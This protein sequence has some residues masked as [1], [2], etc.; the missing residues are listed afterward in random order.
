MVE[1]GTGT[2]QYFVK[3]VPTVYMPLAGA[4]VQTYQFSVTEHLRPIEAASAGAEAAQG[5][6][7]GVFFNYEL[8]PLRAHIE[9]KRRSAVHFL[10][11]LFGV[12]GGVFVVAG[13][14]DAFVYALLEDL[15]KGRGRGLGGGA[16]GLAKD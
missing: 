13:V 8:S 5:V 14:A 4:A 15:K 3:L 2:H 10:T 12:V 7:P 1:S 16:L 9:E 11:R 6:L